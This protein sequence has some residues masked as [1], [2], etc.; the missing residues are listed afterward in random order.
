MPEIQQTRSKVEDLAKAITEGPETEHPT[1][2]PGWVVLK[3]PNPFAEPEDGSSEGLFL[4]GK[5][6]RL[7]QEALQALEKDE[8]VEHLINDN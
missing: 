3:T 7:Y 8:A 5:R 2:H 6:A 4:A 1:S